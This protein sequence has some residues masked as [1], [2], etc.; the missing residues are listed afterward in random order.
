MSDT[1]TSQEPDHKPLESQDSD[2]ANPAEDSAKKD[3]RPVSRPQAVTRPEGRLTP[4][5]EQ[6]WD[7]KEAN[8]GSLLLYRMGDFYELFF[9]DAHTAA[10]VL[11]IAVSHRGEAAGQPV[12]MAGVPFHAI[13]S[14]LARLIRAGHRVAICEQVETPEQAKKRAG[15]KALVKREVIRIVTPGT[16]TEDSLLDARRHNYIAALTEIGGKAGMSWLDISTGEYHTARIDMTDLTA[17]LE[18]LD[19][20]ELV[21]PDRLLARE[22]LYELWASERARLTPEADS[23][24]SFKSAE[25]RLKEHFEVATLYGFGDLSRP[26]IAAAGGLLAYVELTQIGRLPRLHPPR[27]EPVQGVMEIDAAT[28]RNLELMRTLSGQRKGSLLAVMDRTVT[29]G[30]AR[31]L[32]A[33]LSAPLADP[34]RIAERLDAVEA[35]KLDGMLREDLRNALKQCPDIDRALN[36]LSLDRGGPRDLAAIRQG[37]EAAKALQVRLSQRM[38][39]AKL[40]PALEQALGDLGEHSSLIDR[41]TR[42]LVQDP[43]LLAR[44]GGFIAQGFSPALDEMLELRDASKGLLARLAE[45]YKAET[46]IGS[47]KIKSNNVLGT[48]IEVS[49]KAADP[50]M[51]DDNFIH[52]QTLASAVRFTTGELADLEQKRAHA[53]GNAQQLELQLFATLVSDVLDHGVALSR[54]AQGLAALDVAAALAEGAVQNNWTRP[55]I[56]ASRDFDITGGRH[57]VVEAALQAEAAAPFSANDCQMSESDH[58]WLLTGPNMAGKSTFLRQNALIAVMGQMGSF[59]PAGKARF[60]AVDRLFSRVGAADDLARGRST[61]MVEMVET[62]AILNRAGQRAL[63]ILDEIGRGTATFDGL[64]IAWAVVEYLAGRVG[65]R[66]LFATHYHELTQLEGKLPMLSCHSMAV[67]E[68]KGDVVFLHKVVDGAADR[69]YG[70][71]V[72]R[73]AGLPDTVLTRAEQVLDMLEESGTHPGG[74]LSLINELPLFAAAT[75][76]EADAPDAPPPE[77]PD[78]IHQALSL[79]D[80]DDLTPRAALQALYDLRATLDDLERD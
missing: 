17:L 2:S 72:A 3:Q 76:P 4:M 38:D 5:M 13:D 54:T 44:D 69:S 19:P 48:F 49:A 74:Q 1:V 31:L 80:P 30:G 35:L 56:D 63:V 46:G 27:P 34:A 51:S 53:Q 77:E 40:P 70:I 59:V 7:L 29:A 25:T 58:L 57:P 18:R 36:R 68:W 15:S 22:D 37:L 8:P 52:R 62:A 78:P 65:C 23:R 20:Q 32:A 26:E 10:A 50:L 55:A 33:R 73:L 60:G 41:L 42:A 75:A 45:R 79:I 24:F 47:L 14:Y 61:F 21:V 6:Y 43:P 67:K 11:D 9:E 66:A 16:L 28:R 12:P 39:E 64:S 71:H